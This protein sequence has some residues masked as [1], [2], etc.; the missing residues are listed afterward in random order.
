MNKKLGRLFWPGLAVYFVL[1]GIFVA[2]TLAMHFGC[3]VF[4]MRRLK[5]RAIKENWNMEK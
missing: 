2:A 4:Q 3:F 1:M 5:V